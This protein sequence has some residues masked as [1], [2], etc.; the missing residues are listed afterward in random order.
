M[1]NIA[2]AIKYGRDVDALIELYNQNP[3][4]YVVYLLS[5]INDRK[6][7]FLYN[8]LR[9]K[10]Y[11]NKF[12]ENELSDASKTWCDMVYFDQAINKLKENY[13]GEIIVKKSQDNSMEV[14]TN[15]I[16]D[17]N[18]YTIE[19]L[20]EEAE[21]NIALKV[22]SCPIDDFEKNA[23]EISEFKYIVLFNYISKLDAINKLVEQMSEEQ[24][25][26]Y[27]LFVRYTEKNEADIYDDLFDDISV[28]NLMEYI[29]EYELEVNM[30]TSVRVNVNTELRIPMRDLLEHDY[31]DL[32]DYVMDD[33]ECIDIIQDNLEYE[34]K[35]SDF[36]DFYV[37]EVR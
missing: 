9:N 13:K 14:F 11:D 20:M 36:D 24:F 31:Y 25:E 21:N 22:I 12:I 8:R 1:S 35:Y 28:E 10:I 19:E 30:Y 5:P 16:H 27:Q 23:K 33:K 29:E 3:V 32:A 26:E 15:Y 2:Y 17:I 4:N 37:D 18:T 34:L 7:E 6:L